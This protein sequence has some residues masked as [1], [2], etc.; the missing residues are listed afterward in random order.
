M[1]YTARLKA[2]YAYLSDDEI[3]NFINDA[4]SVILDKM[5]ATN[6]SIDYTTYTFTSRF[7]S[8][9]FEIANE[10]VGLNGVSSFTSYKENGISWARDKSGV[11]QSLLERIPVICGTVP[12]TVV[13]EEEV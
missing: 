13:T 4:K 9:I 2:K 1:D 5:Y 10:L 8:L 7:D 6:M 12:L 3:A 11:S